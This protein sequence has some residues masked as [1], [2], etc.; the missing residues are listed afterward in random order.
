MRILVT[1]SSGLIGSA[2]VPFLEAQGHSVTRL[3][4]KQSDNPDEIFWDPEKGI[5]DPSTLEGFDLV[6]HLTGEN[7]AAKRWSKK[8]KERLFLSRVRATWLLSQALT[9]LSSPPKTFISASACGFYGDRGEE[10]LTETSGKG[11]GFL[12]DLSEKWEAATNAAREK[13]IRVV[14]A[15]FGVALSPKGGMLA[16]LLP[17][18]RLGLG[19]KLGAGK[20]LLP[21]IALE[22][23]VSAIYHVAMKDQI[24]GPVNFAAPEP[25]T[26][27]QFSDALAKALH[28]PA[29]FHL[30]AWLLRLILGEMAEELLLVSQGVY[31]QLLLESGFRFHYPDLDSYIS[32]I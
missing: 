12:A 13:G 21:W 4:R 30:P 10:R 9:R 7:I 27:G 19:G 32:S 24:Q 5:I 29:F 17:I 18:Y 2:L 3:V 20:Q 11:A 8:Q 15:R 16:K 1:G 31:P 26:Q 23:L 25:V 14:N 28:R 6:I 22:D